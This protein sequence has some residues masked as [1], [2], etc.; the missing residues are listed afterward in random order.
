[1]NRGFLSTDYDEPKADKTYRGLVLKL[2]L[3]SKKRT[4]RFATGDPVYDF[5]A[6]MRWMANDPTE[7]TVINY[8]SSVDHFFMD[9]KKYDQ[10]YVTF[11]DDKDTT[12][13]LMNYV[14]AVKAGHDTDMLAKAVCTKEMRTWADVK[15]YV[16]AKE[17]EL[18][19]RIRK[20]FTI[21]LKR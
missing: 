4:I 6:Y 13:E 1:M 2:S 3:G 21:G 8:S 7:I 18:G 11:K 14:D 17:K 19:V 15:S 20:D 10:K 5:F 16:L 12:G 9:S